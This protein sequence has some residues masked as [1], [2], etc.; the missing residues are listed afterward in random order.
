M[1]KKERS[2]PLEPY[3][4]SNENFDT[5]PSQVIL[6]RMSNIAKVLETCCNLLVHI[7]R[8]SKITSFNLDKFNFDVAAIFFLERLAIL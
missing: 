5:P 4:L 3:A 7:L 2:L 8:R 6:I 1:V